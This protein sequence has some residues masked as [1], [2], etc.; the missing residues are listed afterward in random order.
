MKK[1][2]PFIVTIAGLLTIALLILIITGCSGSKE[3]VEKKQAESPQDKSSSATGTPPDISKSSPP[4]EISK[5]A[6]QKNPEPVVSTKAVINESDLDV[7]EGI[8]EGDDSSLD[9]PTDDTGQ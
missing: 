8:D 2:S 7:N 5:P 9:I 4:S 3:P 1:N 6:E